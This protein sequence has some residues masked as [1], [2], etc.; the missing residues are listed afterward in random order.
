MPPTTHAPM[1]LPELVIST[2]NHPYSHT[3]SFVPLDDGRVFHAAGSVCNFSEDGGLTW[4]EPQWMKDTA[5]VDVYSTSALKLRDGKNSL[6]LVGRRYT[7]PEWKHPWITFAGDRQLVFWR[8]DDLGKTWAPPVPITPPAFFDCVSLVDSAIV[9]RSGRIVVP[10][11]FQVPCTEDRPMPHP[12][13][14]VRGQWANTV[15]HHFDKGITVIA[16]CYSDDGGR[17]WKKNREGTLFIMQDMNSICRKVN[18]ASITEIADAPGRLLMMMRTHLGRLYQS[19]SDDNG[20]TWCEPQ[21][22]LLASTSAPAQ[23]RTLPNGHLLCIWNQQSEEEFRKGYVR[24]RLSSAISRDGGSIWEF[25]QNIESIHD[26][27]FVV[28]GPI[29]VVRPAMLYAPPGQPAVECDPAYVEDSPHEGRW[30]YPSVC[31]LK[32]RVIVA[33][34]AGGYLVDHPTEARMIR[35]GTGGPDVNTDVGIDLS[36]QQIRKVL[37][38]KWFYGGKEPVDGVWKRTYVPARTAGKA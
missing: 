32:D 34:S 37:P 18:E 21:P 22:T 28:P 4:P 7:D 27:S 14:L 8:S 10:I 9:T 25:F 12:G 38:L 1:T 15:G 30:T 5:G 2:Q 35:T 13:R 23:I 33:Y 3:S 17:T 6:G 20:E 16:V 26:T 31:V 36:I 11:Y 24:T 19:W 29:R